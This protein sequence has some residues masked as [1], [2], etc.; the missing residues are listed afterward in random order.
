MQNF[1]ASR[2]DENENRQ[3]FLP[4]TPTVLNVIVAIHLNVVGL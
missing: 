2:S 1:L 3:V 4:S